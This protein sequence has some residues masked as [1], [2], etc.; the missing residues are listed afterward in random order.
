MKPIRAHFD[1]GLPVHRVEHLTPYGADDAGRF[2]RTDAAHSPANCLP[3]W[4]PS[5]LD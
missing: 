2:Y 1:P 5:S 4:E 3:S